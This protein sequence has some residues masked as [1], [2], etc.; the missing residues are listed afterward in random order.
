MPKLLEERQRCG[1]DLALRVTASGKGAE[2]ISSLAIED[3][4][5]EDRTC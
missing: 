2:S 1:M 3:S 5:G 4:L